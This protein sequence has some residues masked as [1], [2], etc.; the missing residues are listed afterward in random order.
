MDIC[1]TICGDG[2]KKGTEAWDDGNTSNLD[3]CSSSW[4][5]E[6]GWI[7]TGSISSVWTGI[8]GDNKR[9]ASESCDDGTQNDGK[10]WLSDCTGTI[11]GW[12]WSG[13]NLNQPDTCSEKNEEMGLLLHLKREM[14][15]M[16]M[17]ELDAQQIDRELFLD[18][19]EC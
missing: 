6:S 3:G 11:N 7:W 8:W 18:I 14:M 2:V 4:T 9:V 5:I 12:H 16:L 19:N 13:G 17:M 10:G 15:E 1:T